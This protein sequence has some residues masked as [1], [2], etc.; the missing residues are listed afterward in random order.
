LPAQEHYLMLTQGMVFRLAAETRQFPVI[1]N[2][3]VEII[4]GGA[5]FSARVQP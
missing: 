3:A 5:S 1:L 2:D 4:Y